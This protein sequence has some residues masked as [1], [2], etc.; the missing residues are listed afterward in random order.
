LAKSSIRVLVVDD[1]EPFRRSICSALQDKLELRTIVEA[2]DGQ[3]AI[4]L[5]QALQADLILM[6][7]GLPKLDGIE[8]ARRISELAP[9]SKTLF[10]SQ[11]SSADVV[12]AAFSAGASGY[13][14]KMDAGSELP[15]RES[16]SL[17]RAV[18]QGQICGPRFCPGLG[19]TTLW[20]RR[21]HKVFQFPQPQNIDIALIGLRS[22]TNASVYFVLQ[23]FKYPCFISSS[24]AGTT[25]FGLERDASI[26]RGPACGLRR[27]GELTFHQ[28]DSFTHADEP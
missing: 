7:I 1:F 22:E 26:N 10:V 14:V 18:C 19:C 3:D 27:D 2:S 21:R 9:K 20:W 16:C 15:S 11:E 25:F 28:M 8:A 5:A 12:Q 13:V 17:E 24:Q 23:L 6:D 4:E